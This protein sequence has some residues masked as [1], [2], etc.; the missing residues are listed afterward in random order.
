MPIFEPLSLQQRFP[1]KFVWGVATS[2]FQIE[3]ASTSDEKGPSIW[4]T[5]THTKGK[6]K[7]G[8]TGDVSVDF[9]NRFHTDIE[10]IKQMNMQVNRFSTSW[11][12]V[13]PEGIGM[14]NQKGLDFYHRVIDLTL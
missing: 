10:F 13:L 8:E 11:S 14:V 2:A 7:T 3:G 5:F 9:Y 12:R 4:D 6:I 1:E